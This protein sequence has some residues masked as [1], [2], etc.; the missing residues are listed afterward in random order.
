[1]NLLQESGSIRD[2]ELLAVSGAND[3]AG[4][5]SIEYNDPL[6]ILYEQ[7]VSREHKR[8]EPEVVQ[9]VQRNVPVAVYVHLACVLS[10][11]SIYKPSAY[12][13]GREENDEYNPTA[14]LC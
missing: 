4:N 10:V 11:S 2:K 3:L 12:E 5:R 8:C 13:G 7:I 6:V 14:L 9:C 1:M